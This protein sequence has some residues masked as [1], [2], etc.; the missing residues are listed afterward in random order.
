MPIKEFLNKKSGI[1][2]PIICSRCGKRVG[3]VTP[4]MRFRIKFIIYGAILAFVVQFIT[5]LMSDY[6]LKTLFNI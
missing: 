1:G 3:T 6:L 2:K 5:Q 4:R